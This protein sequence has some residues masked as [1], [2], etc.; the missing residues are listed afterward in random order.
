MIPYLRDPGQIARIAS[1]ISVSHGCELFVVLSQIRKLLM[2]SL[3]MAMQQQVHLMMRIQTRSRP[4]SR[5]KSHVVSLKLWFIWR[6]LNCMHHV[7]RGQGVMR[8]TQKCWSCKLLW[9]GSSLSSV[10]QQSKSSLLQLSPHR[11]TSSSTTH[12]GHMSQCLNC[13]R[14]FCWIQGGF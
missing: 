12:C 7:H 14:V 8:C 10:N 1:P 6:S 9:F 3:A 5:S 2:R 4:Q 11:I 13:Q